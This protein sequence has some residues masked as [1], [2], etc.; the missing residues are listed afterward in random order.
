MSKSAPRPRERENKGRENV[1]PVFIEVI[2]Q[3]LGDAISRSVAADAEVGKVVDLLQPQSCCIECMIP[4]FIVGFE[5]LVV[6]V[7]VHLVVQPLAHGIAK[8]LIVPVTLSVSL[9]EF[10]VTHVAPLVH[11]AREADV[12]VVRDVVVS[13]SDCRGSHAE[14][15]QCYHLVES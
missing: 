8:Q 7:I 14:V 11:T 15:S 3:Q 1:L 13:R 9:H 2:A 4:P 12:L 6:I 10:L 5:V